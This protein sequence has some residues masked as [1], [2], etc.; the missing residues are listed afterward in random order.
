M[1]WWWPGLSLVVCAAWVGIALFNVFDLLRVPWL[2]KAGTGRADAGAAGVGSQTDPAGAR[3]SVGAGASERVQVSVIIPAR[4][5]QE[6]LPMTLAAWAE[7]T[8]SEFEVIVVDD[9]SEDATGALADAFA[10]SHPGF[11]VLH[12][13]QLPVGWLGK[14]Y[15]LQKGAEAAAGSWLLFADA[16]VCFAPDALARTMEYV[17]RQALDHLTVAP[18][19]VARG[20]WLRA[21]TALF[22]YNL[23]LF[24]RP[25]MAHRA[26]SRAYAGIGAFN[27]VRKSVYQRMGGHRA[28]A[29][30]PDDDIQLG[31]LVKRVHGRQQ[32]ALAD[33]FMQIEWYPSLRDMVKG[34]EKSP[35]AA[36]HYSVGKLVASLIPL[37]LLYDGPFACALLAPGWWRLA[38]VGALVIM[39]LLYFMVNRFLR[40]PLHQFLVLPVT[41]CLFIYTFVRSAWQALRRGGL[42]W[43]GT[44]YPLAELRR[45]L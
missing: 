8:Y 23:V 19:V 5:E 40:F 43:R 34:L 3:P 27:L 18:R 1:N 12:I 33:Q 31:R 26:K 41:L 14:N 22:A 37:L 16:D 17:G 4:N 9:R 13:A 28:L 44:L 35:L 32:F 15:A 7:Q 25:H 39:F 6:R 24:K 20:Y 2:P 36:F 42:L 38:G 10:Q 11:R 45:G 29:L 21:L 30:R